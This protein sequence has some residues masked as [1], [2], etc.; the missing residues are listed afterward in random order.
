MQNAGGNGLSK[1]QSTFEKVDLAVVA[2]TKTRYISGFEDS[3][4]PI[5]G[6]RRWFAFSAKRSPGTVLAGLISKKHKIYEEI[7]KTCFLGSVWEK[8][9][10]RSTH[11]KLKIVMFAILWAFVSDPTRRIELETIFKAE[12]SLW[13]PLLGTSYLWHSVGGGRLPFAI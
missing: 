13:R 1:K 8:H 2:V 6:Q 12:I 9:T 3:R 4:R 7:T 10:Y 11:K 5:P